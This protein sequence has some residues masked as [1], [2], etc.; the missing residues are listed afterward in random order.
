LPDSPSPTCILAALTSRRLAPSALSEGAEGPQWIGN[1]DHESAA[2]LRG[3]PGLH[4]CAATLQCLHCC[5]EAPHGCAAAR[6]RARRPRAQPV[7]RPLTLVQT[8]T[9]HSRTRT[10]GGGAWA[11]GGAGG[12]AAGRAPRRVRPNCLRCDRHRRALFGEKA[13][14]PKNRRA[15]AWP[16]DGRT[17]GEMATRLH[18]HGWSDGR[19]AVKV[20]RD[21]SAAARMRGIRQLSQR[22]S[23]PL[24]SAI[25]RSQ[26]LR[27][28]HRGTRF[29]AAS[30]SL[31]AP[32][33]LF[34]SELS[35][36]PPTAQLQ[37]M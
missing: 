5:A 15:P 27:R 11:R 28:L 7:A 8:E 29:N 37:K 16:Q 3:S 24:S 2:W 20:L 12:G 22:H 32:S 19:A 36:R 9:L 25:E 31:K 1:V 21:G 23:E 26:G 35:S 13:S 14:K 17:A 10:H 34:A 33:R 18:S 6:G 30:V 4:G